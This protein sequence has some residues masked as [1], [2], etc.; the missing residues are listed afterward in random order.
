MFIYA[1]AK[2]VVGGIETLIMRMAAWLISNGHEVSLVVPHLPPKEIAVPPGLLIY[3]LQHDFDRLFNFSQ[4]GKIWKS[5]GLPSVDIIKAFEIASAWIVPILSAFMVAPPK[6]IVGFYRPIE[7]ECS[8]SFRHFLQR[9]LFKNIIKN[10]APASRLFMSEDVLSEFLA[11]SKVAECGS[12]WPLPVDPSPFQDIQRRPKRHRIISI[13]RLAPMK[14]YNEVMLFVMRDLLAKG[15]DVR[16]TVYG[17]GAFRGSLEQQRDQLGLRNL[18]E[19]KGSIKY[20]EMA[21][22]LTDA[23]AFVGMGTAAIEASMAGVPSVVA[24]AH[25]ATGATYGCLHHLPFGNCG[26]RMKTPPPRTIA[27]ELERL[28]RL[29]DSDYAHECATARTAALQYDIDAAMR[30]FLQLVEHAAPARRSKFLGALFHLYMITR[31]IR[32]WIAAKLN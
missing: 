8:A 10:F 29:S 23:Y 32:K 25:D 30:R 3:E 18:V 6:A 19:F 26:D 7:A 14:E 16:W 31:R 17:D 20:S 11:T 4:A 5:R 13:G 2:P 9:I 15:L 12:F 1:S 22:V 27:A 24:I 21:G 28:L